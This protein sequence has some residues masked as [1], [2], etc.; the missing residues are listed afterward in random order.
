MKRRILLGSREIGEGCPCFIVAEAGSNHNGS[1][2]MARQ[3]IEVAASAGADAVKF[4]LF[5]AGKLYPRSAGMSDYLKTDRPIYDIISEM[6]MPYDWLPVLAE[7]CRRRNLTFLASVFD[8]ESADRLDPFVP[9]FKIASYEMTHL[10]LVRYI[11][12]KGKPV[13]LATGTA[14]L[15]EVRESVEAF[16]QTGNVRL[17]LM[18]CTAAYPAPLPFLNVRAVQTMKEA[19]EVPVGLS[20]HSGDPIVGPVA[21]VAL[22]ANL[23]EKH[24]T[25]SRQLPGPDHSFAVEPEELALLVRKV[26]EAEEALGSG[27]K[28][29][30]PVERELRSFARRQIVAVQDIH[31]GEKFT[32]ENAAV[33]RRGKLA[34]GLEP[35]HFEEILGKVARRSISGGSA[36]LE[37][38]LG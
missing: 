15:E 31:V 7:A 1:L 13:I 17:V 20:D 29:V 18:Q 12:Q 36:I 23:I 34:P 33:L 2:S 25:L 8:E 21:A 30:Q 16:R 32:R 3:L 37:G 6:E 10:P 35:K 28:V 14:S 27:E 9:A 38:D 19:F 11:A 24:F 26:R 4:Q 5:R 22:G